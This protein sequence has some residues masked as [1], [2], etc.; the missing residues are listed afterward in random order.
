M[1][2]LTRRNILTLNLLLCGAFVYTCVLIKDDFF[3]YD[4]VP[5]FADWHDDVP[6]GKALSD[7]TGIVEGSLYGTPGKLTGKAPADKTQKMTPA[8]KP[9]QL[10]KTISLKGTIVPGYAIFEDKV[11]KQQQ[12][13]KEGEEIFSKGR[14][15]SVEENQ[16]RILKHGNLYTYYLPSPEK[17]RPSPTA[18]RAATRSPSARIQPSDALSTDVPERNR[19]TFEKSKVM[20]V[21]KDIN[22]VLHDAKLTLY[23]PEESDSALGYKVSE[24]TK[25]GI[26][27][28][29]GIKDGDVILEVNGL[30]VTDKLNWGKLFS[31]LKSQ[32]RFNVDI[33]RNGVLVRLQ[34]KV[35]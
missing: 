31:Q 8:S 19:R 26:F 16:A 25:S 33:V 6:G 15:V 10:D 18:A 22:A 32:P 3:G 7:Y 35:Q 12:L 20:S 1:K 17:S 13:F 24:V 14:L 9:A 28:Q 23:E 11:K 5:S 21:V 29:G 2:A 4:F 27:H 30:D 34:Y